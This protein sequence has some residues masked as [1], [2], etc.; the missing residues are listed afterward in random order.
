[1]KF[2]TQEEFGLRCLMEL[3]RAGEGA[4]L[5]I[6]QISRSEGIS[7][8]NVAKI[9]RLLRRAGFVRSTRGQT[10]GYS[11][12]GSPAGIVVGH[13]LGALGARLFDPS[14]CKRHGGSEE[15]FSCSGCG[16]CDAAKLT[17]VR[18]AGR[19]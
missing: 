1:M 12:S 19:P 2:S 15:T 16:S 17:S 6:A 13:V 7:M 18:A 11:L 5:T 10:G 4:S 8:P 14:F 3:G 9:L